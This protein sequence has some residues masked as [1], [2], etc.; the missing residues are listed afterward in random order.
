[1]KLSFSTFGYGSFL[2]WVPAYT[3]EEAVKRIAGF[4]YDGIE[5]GASRP[6]AWPAD[7]D[8]T[9]RKKL[10]KMIN[11][12]GLEIAAICPVVY[13]FNLAS[14]IENERKDTIE[15]YIK[16]IRLATDLESKVV[17]FVP[18]WSVYPTSNEES[19]KRMKEGIHKISD[20]TRDLNV[21]MAIEPINSYWADL[22]TR[23]DDA[24]RLIKEMN[25]ENLKIM[26]DT[27][28]LYLERENPV[29]AVEKCGELLVH[30]HIGDTTGASSERIVTGKGD[31]GFETFITALEKAGYKYYLSAELWG[32]NPDQIALEN[33]KYLKTLT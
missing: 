25:L 19:W 32:P 18:G 30:V 17:V 7:L 16:C 6:H 33:I 9:S 28:H 4:H 13:E 31:F 21:S 27:Q 8:T 22:V 14:C 11:S 15:Y 3:L 20:R 10:K 5:I 1:M 23:T 2:P 12:Y 24:L 26:L 29:D